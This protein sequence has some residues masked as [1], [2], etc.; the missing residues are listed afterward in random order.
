MCERIDDTGIKR[1]RDAVVQ[2]AIHDYRQALKYRN[3]GKVTAMERW[4]RS[5]YG[6]LFTGGNGELVIQRCRK[7]AERR[8][9]IRREILD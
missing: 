2:A 8:I 7:D 9:K 5:E 4:F 1:L 3:V 6:Q